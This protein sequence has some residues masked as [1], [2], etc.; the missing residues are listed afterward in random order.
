MIKF[1]VL[2]FFYL[3][4]KLGICECVSRCLCRMVWAYFASCFYA[5]DY[6]CTFFCVKLRLLKRTNRRSR[7][8][9]RIIEMLDTS[10]SGDDAPFTYMD[11]SIRSI[12]HRRRDYRGA[13]LRKSLRPRN[14]HVRAG[15]SRELVYGHRRNSINKHNNGD[16]HAGRV[17]GIRVT[18]TS[19]FA[20]KG[21]K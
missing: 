6:C 5:C 8:R 15:I 13:H 12:S 14:H 11:K 7:R 20:H 2:L 1:A 9:K 17:H 16:Q 4:Y 3:L 10:S 21:S 18:R 19:R